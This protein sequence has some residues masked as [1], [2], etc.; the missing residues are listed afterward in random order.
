MCAM[1]AN[2]TTFCNPYDLSALSESWSYPCLRL[3]CTRAFRFILATTHVGMVTC[4]R[5][6]ITASIFHIA[7]SNQGTTSFVFSDTT[8]YRNGIECEA[9]DLFILPSKVDCCRRADTSY[10]YS[11]IV[12]PNYELLKYFN[13]PITMR[14]IRPSTKAMALFHHAHKKAM[15]GIHNQESLINSVIECL[16][17]S[18]AHIFK[19]SNQ[20]RTVFR[21]QQIL[22]DIKPGVDSIEDICRRLRV[23]E[24]TLRRAC[25]SY[26]GMTPHEYIISHRLNMARITFTYSD[27][28]SVKVSDIAD[29]YGFSDNSRFARLYRNLFGETPSV[30]LRSKIS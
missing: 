9:G 4:L 25:S 11:A 13:E 6:K 22:N 28:H 3:V 14:K 29:Q 5:G 7:G 18:D 21:F 19:D 30:T 1:A 24:R 8:L 26:L 2:I 12:I 23:S 10:K 20:E 27:P 15:H 17:N 16:Y